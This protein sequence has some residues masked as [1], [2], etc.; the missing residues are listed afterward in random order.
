MQATTEFPAYEAV[1]AD[2]GQPRAD[3]RHHEER[4]RGRR[5]CWVVLTV[6]RERKFSRT[7]GLAVD[8]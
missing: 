5:C 1:D 3:G 2:I 6:D 7:V 4:K 8:L